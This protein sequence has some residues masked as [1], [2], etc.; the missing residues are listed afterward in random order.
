MAGQS[1]KEKAER[2]RRVEED[3]VAAWAAMLNPVFALGQ[4]YG[5]LDALRGRAVAR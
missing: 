2:R 3:A 1:T 5:E 4:A